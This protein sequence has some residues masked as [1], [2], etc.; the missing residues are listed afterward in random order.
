MRIYHLEASKMLH[1]S[2]NQLQMLVPKG[3]TFKHFGNYHA[4]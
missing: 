2:K 3:F 1:L 4:T